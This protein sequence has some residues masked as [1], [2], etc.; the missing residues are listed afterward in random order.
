MADA[1]PADTPLVSILIPVYNGANYLAEAIDSALAQTWK[2]LE[3][4]VIDDGSE[5]ETAAICAR[6]GERIRYF[7][8]VNGGVATALNL[9]LRVMRGEFFSWLSHDDLYTPDRI[10]IMVGEYRKRMRRGGGDLLLCSDFDVLDGDGAYLDTARAPRAVGHLAAVELVPHGCSMLVP[11]SHF[12]RAGGFHPGLPT[13]QDADMWLRLQ[14]DARLEP[15]GR[16]TVR[17]RLHDAQGSRAAWHLAEVSLNRL[18]MLD[19]VDCGFLDLGQTSRVE[20]YL[21]LAR[22]GRLAATPGVRAEASRRLERAVETATIGLV[23]LGWRGAVSHEV[24]PLL[25]RNGYRVTLVRMPRHEPARLLAALAELEF[26]RLWLWDAPFE[27]AARMLELLRPMVGLLTADPAIGGALPPP[28][29]VARSP[30]LRGLHGALVPTGALRSARSAGGG[31]W[32]SVAHEVVRRGGFRQAAEPLVQARAPASAAVAGFPTS[33]PAAPQAAPAAPV[34]PTIASRVVRDEDAFDGRERV[35]RARRAG[36]RSAAGAVIGLVGLVWARALGWSPVS[37]GVGRL[38]AGLTAGCDAMGRPGPLH[39]LFA[40][41]STR[42]ALS[43]GASRLVWRLA[44]AAEQARLWLLDLHGLDGHFD[45]AWYRRTYADVAASGEDPLLHYL[46]IG[47][48]ERRDPSAGFDTEAYLADH[49]DV[50]ARGLHAVQHYA[51]WGVAEGRRVRRSRRDAAV[52]ARADR[53][54]LVLLYP[55]GDAHGVRVVRDLRLQLGRRARVCVVAWSGERA[56]LVDPDADLPP[57]GALAEVLAGLARDCAVDQ[58]LV[59]DPFAD[60]AP[61][62]ALAA[63]G[64]P[65]DVLHTRAAPAPDLAGVRN[66]YVVSHALAERT[67]RQR[68]GPACV[69][70][71][72]PDANGTRRLRPWLRVRHPREFCRV[73]IFGELHPGAGLDTVREALRLA[74]RWHLPMSFVLFGRIEDAVVAGDRALTVIEPPTDGGSCADAL[75]AFNPH[76][77]WV[78]ERDPARALFA[79]AAAVESALPL[80]AVD[81]ADAR[82]FL[83][84]RPLTWLRSPRGALAWLGLLDGIHRL[85]MAHDAWRPARPLL[86]FDASRA[87]FAQLLL[88]GA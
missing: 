53:K 71:P 28:G 65:C 79:L 78:P 86:G 13:T 85:D 88:D 59:I 75:A 35:L 58:A 38:A 1:A 3:V 27:P 52:K 12:E 10:E 57:A 30:L 40:R 43:A 21:R 76:V 11:R 8:K 15:V 81:S 20:Q 56:T 47:L 5:D 32:T 67:L 77:A 48:S 70:V 41:L 19:R 37:R 25:W 55:A 46:R 87:A 84:G 18:S 45:A 23:W 72:L 80:A 49:P 16:V 7:Y 22:G 34:E 42:P 44:P 60:A 61:L 2:P 63:R 9:G 54:A 82:D 17:S 6:Y 33:I 24:L 4:V 66:H 62:T 64:I 50:A 73:A 29:S 74:G 39:R 51:L 36:H 83:A 69:R 31:V 26:D 68:P 14:R